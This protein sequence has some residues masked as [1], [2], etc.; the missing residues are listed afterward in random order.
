MA[1]CGVWAVLVVTV[2]VWAALVLPYFALEGAREDGF[3]SPAQG[4]AVAGTGAVLAAVTATLLLRLNCGDPGVVRAACHEGGKEE[5]DGPPCATCL[6]PRPPGAHHC[7]VCDC[8]VAGFDHHCPFVGGC[9][10]AGNRVTFVCMLVAAAALS[11]YAAATSAAHFSL[12]LRA[13]D[14]RGSL[15]SGGGR[16]AAVTA[17]AVACALA[18]WLVWRLAAAMWRTGCRPP[19]LAVCCARGGMRAWP[20]ALQWT[21]AVVV[22]LVVVCVTLRGWAGWPQRTPAGLFLALPLAALG[23][24][25]AGFA[26]VHWALLCM[27]ETTKG[28]VRRANAV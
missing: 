18:A 16:A 23:A 13:A 26:A 24:F 8:C 20:G 17:A 22:L 10:G 14:R 7:S 3:L 21:G 1:V 5:E 15:R 19:S 2:G 27:G 11:L 12:L 9:V 6:V 4:R 25:L 28:A